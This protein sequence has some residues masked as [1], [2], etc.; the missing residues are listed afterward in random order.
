MNIITIGAGFIS[1]YLPYTLYHNKL[2]PD[3]V[4][5][6]RFI[7]EY[8]PD[9]IIN[10]AGKTGRPNIDWCEEHRT[11]TYTANTVLPLV[12][13]A[14]CEKRNIRM[15]HFGSG[16]VFSGVSPHITILDEFGDYDGGFIENDI[17]NP[18]SYYAN[19]KLATDL[20][21]GSMSNVCILRLRMPIG[22]SLS[23]RNLISKLLGY[24]K[25]LIAKNS[26]SFVD[27]IVNATAFVIEKQLSGIY[28]ITSPYPLYHS[29]ILD[30]YKHYAPT[31]TYEKILP[32]ELDTIVAAPRSNCIL[33]SNKI[34]DK[35]FVFM[36]QNKL[37]RE[38]IR[39]YVK[40]Q[41]KQDGR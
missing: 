23:Q 5:I 1:S 36:D 32:H 8:K 13:A 14:E 39:A 29:Q 11:E 9:V 40:N 18:Q 6:N 26:V 28:H 3:V 15:I 25:V 7:D 38:Y 10:A 12:L 16:C 35:G 22:N 19:T 17:A 21:I 34:I 37:L 20:A 41:R 27:D 33:N 2:S 31:H 4:S 30:E 24:K